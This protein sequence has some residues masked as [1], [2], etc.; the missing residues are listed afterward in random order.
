MRAFA[1]ATL[2]GVITRVSFCVPAVLLGVAACS[3]STQEKRPKTIDESPQITAVGFASGIEDRG[4]AYA[5]AGN[6]AVASLA[7]LLKPV[8]FRLRRSDDGSSLD[9]SQDQVKIA[10]ANKGFA[11]LPDGKWM[12][13]ASIATPPALIAR[14]AKLDAVEAEVTISNNDV[15]A[16]YRVAESRA[17]RKLVEASVADLPMGEHQGELIISKLD[18]EIE[19]TKVTVRAAGRAT[20]TKHAALSDK[21]SAE[22][23]NAALHEYRISSDHTKL[24][25]LLVTVAERELAASNNLVAA[26][27][28]AEAAKYDGTQRYYDL[29]IAALEG[30]E[31]SPEHARMSKF[32]QEKVEEIE[33]QAELQKAATETKAD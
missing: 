32:L 29:A 3:S 20:V 28:Y 24:E 7:K 14:N 26:Q 22:L 19:G 1:L 15:A 4:L 17:L 8:R 18:P 11:E 30:V 27:R 21:A 5:A 25:P 6:R 31:E 2:R 13:R 16:A 23:A 10:G 33:K 9:L 12:S